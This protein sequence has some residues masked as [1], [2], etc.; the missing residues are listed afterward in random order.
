MRGEEFEVHGT[1][2]ETFREAR[3]LINNSG[4]RRRGGRRKALII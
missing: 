2:D 4:G 3:E 1:L